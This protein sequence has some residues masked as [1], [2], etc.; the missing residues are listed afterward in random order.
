MIEV[1]RK[2]LEGA[3]DRLHHQITTYL[4]PLLAALALIAVAWAIALLARWIVYRI[5]KGLAI[6]K[7]L[8]QSGVAFL[9]DPS[10][11]LRATRIVGETVYWG[12]VLTGFLLGVNVFDTDLTSQMV[13]SFVFLLPKLMVAGLIL[14]GG[15]WLGYYLG[16]SMLVWAV[17]ENLPSPRRLA[18]VVRVLI[19]FVAVVAAADQ[20]NFART[21][22]LAAFII[23]VGGVVLAGS[24][25]VG[26]SA[27]GVRQLLEARP[28]ASGESEERSLWSHL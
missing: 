6:D 2:V 22:F 16:R 9:V 15:A 7:F 18:V 12:I 5:F 27:S 13:Q 17:N 11:R 24:L 21:V 10:G 3:V 4:P 14:L 1:L 28:R 20:L 8:R 19:I 23:L 26:L 25:A